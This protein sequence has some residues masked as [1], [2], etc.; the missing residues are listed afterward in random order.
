MAVQHKHL[1]VRSEITRPIVDIAV[2]KSL[3]ESLVKDIG[4]KLL[5]GYEQEGKGT[6]LNPIATYCP[7]EGNRGLTACALIETSH[8]VLHIWD[9]ENPS[10]LELDVYTC[11]NLNIEQ[12][13]L[14]VERNF[15]P[16]KLTYW[17]LD[18]KDDIVQESTHSMEY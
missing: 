2:I 3:M 13:E 10:L 11:A 1:I 7:I 17:L 16:K 5:K 8:I 9:E 12:V 14:W 15:K 18:R 4:M 6:F